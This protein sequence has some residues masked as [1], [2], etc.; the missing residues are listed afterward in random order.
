LTAATLSLKPSQLAGHDG[1][2][3][4]VVQVVGRPAD[5]DGP[6]FV[7]QRDVLQAV[8]EVQAPGP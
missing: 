2:V 6:L 3:S 5:A 1:K 4:L 7:H 8:V